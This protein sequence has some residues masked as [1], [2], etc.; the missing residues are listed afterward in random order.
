MLYGVCRTLKRNKKVD[1]E[2]R[3]VLMREYEQHP[4]L[5]LAPMR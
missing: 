1:F 4:E 2:Y 5:E 3:A